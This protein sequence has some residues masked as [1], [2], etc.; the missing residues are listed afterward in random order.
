MRMAQGAAVG[1]H[2]PPPG[3]LGVSITAPSFLYWLDGAWGQQ[4][5]CACLR[6]CAHCK[7][8]YVDF[9]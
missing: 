8:L 1:H 6:R 7:V 3:S 9:I 4:P 5:M 2:P